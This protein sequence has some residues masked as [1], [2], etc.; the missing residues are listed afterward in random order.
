M[1]LLSALK[2]V[3]SQWKAIDLVSIQN[4]YNSGT[5]LEISKL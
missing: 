5:E 3:L 4:T 2:Q 1:N